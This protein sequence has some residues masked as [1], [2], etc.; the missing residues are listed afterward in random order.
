MRFN[1]PSLLGSSLLLATVAVVATAPVA[2]APP[3]DDRAGRILDEVAA[4][5]AITADAERLACFDRTAA[6]VAA[7]RQSGQLLVFDRAKVEA[8]RRTQFGL[9]DTPSDA[10]SLAAANAAAV[11][12][13]AS[14]VTKVAQ[15]P[16]ADRW[17]LTLA[18]GQV[19]QTLG[20][21]RFAPRQ[22]AAVRLS[23]TVTGGIRASID[24]RAPIQVR[25]IR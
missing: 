14:T 6:A 19:W 12:T 20:T 23:T 16:T 25:R 15:G 10:G 24:G 7:G 4:C 22:G 17:N 9:V 11:K 8:E 18:N 1:R 21:S 3:R 13:I 5:R 2:A